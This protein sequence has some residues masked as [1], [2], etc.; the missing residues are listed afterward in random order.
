[1]ATRL[2]G[3]LARA[4]ARASGASAARRDAR[5]SRE[6]ASR[7]SRAPTARA[8]SSSTAR[9]RALDRGVASASAPWYA[10]SPSGRA[11]TL[12]YAFASS[13]DRGRWDVFGDF[14]HGG[15]SACELVASS[16][17]G[18]DADEDSS[19]AATA[20]ARRR[21]ALRERYGTLRGRIDCG[22]PPS[23]TKTRLRRSGFAGARTKPL[24][25][26]LVNP[27]PTLDFDAYDALSYRVRGDGRMYVASVRTE[28]W[29]TGDS[30]EDVWQA[31]FR[32]PRDEWVDV[33][34][35]IEAFVQTYRGR[36]VADHARMS[37]N[38]VVFL[39]LAVAGSAETSVEARR[40]EADGPFRLD[41]HSIS[42]LRMTEEEMESR[43]AARDGTREN[44]PCGGFATSAVEA[45]D[46]LDD[47]VDSH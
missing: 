46:A 41:V 29:M 21:E 2:R 42:G 32:P 18:D 11:V 44:Y 30:T 7:A 14:E 17:D 27:D 8:E 5:A 1:M 12:L 13:A 38:R 22:P 24:A 20:T 9:A 19:D 26:T 23:G 33:V 31:A 40:A 39:G 25:K 15:A 10:A 6:V 4:V 35:P 16:D 34:V 37:A 36:A 28:N 3:A 47:F 45:L 43:V